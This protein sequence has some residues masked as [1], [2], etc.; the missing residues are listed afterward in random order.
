MDEEF[1]LDQHGRDKWLTRI[2][3]RQRK[4]LQNYY[5]MSITF[6]RFSF[7]QSVCLI[8]IFSDKLLVTLKLGFILV[9]SLLSYFYLLNKM[10][11]LLEQMNR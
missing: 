2:L 1:I 11:N 10:E 6:Q 7:A 5:M 8:L 3:S 4:S 9:Y